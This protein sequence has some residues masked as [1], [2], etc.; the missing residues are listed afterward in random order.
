[1]YTIIQTKSNYDYVY[2]YENIN[3]NYYKIKIARIKN[4]YYDNYLLKL[5]YKLLL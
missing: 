5:N 2:K 4:Q 3:C 1:M